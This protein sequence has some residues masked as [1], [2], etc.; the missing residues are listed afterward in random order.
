MSD[1]MATIQFTR[2]GD[3]V[4]RVQQQWNLTGT[5]EHDRDLIAS[6]LRA[7][8]D[9]IDQMGENYPVGVCGVAA[10]LSCPVGGVECVEV[11]C[12]ACR[13]IIPEGSEC[14]WCKLHPPR[15]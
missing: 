14:L 1:P 15:I 11:E 10:M 13:D 9:H 7:V 3:D 8:A 2:S 4:L 5:S 12:P 6:S